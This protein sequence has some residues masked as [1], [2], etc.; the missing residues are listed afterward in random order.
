MDRI[1]VLLDT[2]I[3]SDIDDAVCLA[4]LLAQPRCELAGI[5]TV[6][7]QACLRAALADAVCRAA[8]RTDIPIHAGAERGLMSGEV[9]QPNVPQA[10]VLE[11]WA[12]RRAQDF[13]PGTAVE[14]LRRAIE[15]RP[16]ELTLLAIGPMTNAALLFATHPHTAGLLRGVMLMCGIFRTVRHGGQREWNALC[17]PAATAITY[18][19]PAARHRSVP[20]DVTERCVLTAE[21]TMAR[22]RAIGGPMALVADMTSFWGH[23]RTD[24]TYHDPLAA[25]CI[26][27]PELCQW[28]RGRVAV[29]LASTRLAGHT[30]LD[31]AADGPHEVALG[32]DPAA[33]FAEYFAVVGAQA[34]R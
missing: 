33:F 9:V 4:Y 27:R 30:H 22:C 18:R 10:P 5:T 28:T 7:G 34:P 12:A 31:P 6:S 3:G 19:T 32:V 16:G 24:V 11:R 23:G 2:D 25:A 17:D 14:F 8:G 20:I 21:D 29:E 15:A 13:A 1:P 26:F